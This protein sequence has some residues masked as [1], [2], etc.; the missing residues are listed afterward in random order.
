VTIDPLSKMQIQYCRQFAGYRS[1]RDVSRC[2][3]NTNRRWELRFSQRWRCQCWFSVL[4]CL[5]GLQVETI[6]SEK[7]NSFQLQDRRWRQCVFS[8]GDKVESERYADP[9]CRPTPVI[10]V[11][12]FVTICL[13]VPQRRIVLPFLST[14]IFN[15][16]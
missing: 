16:S 6:V 2:G 15:W 7:H 5:M 9:S 4:K 8:M 13:C 11:R 10:K 3:N 14:L 1:R 12:E